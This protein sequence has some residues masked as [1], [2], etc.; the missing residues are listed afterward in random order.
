MNTLI[1]PPITTRCLSIAAPAFNE[2]EGIGALVEH[3][4]HFL[5]ENAAIDRFEIIICNDGSEDNTGL[6][7]EALAA[8]HSEI[9]LIHF[10]LNQGAAAALAAAIAAT[11]FDWVLLMDA[12]GQFPIENL[13]TMLAQLDLGEVKAVSGIRKK[14]D[15]LFARFGTQS[16]GLICNLVHGS[17]LKDFNSACKLVYGP[18]IRSL[19]LEARGMNYS[20][21]V[22]SKLLESRIALVEIDIDHR[23][24]PMGK[25]K[26]R[27]LRD[28]MHRLLFVAYISWRQLLFKLKILRR[29]YDNENSS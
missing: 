21:E 17:Q 8:L 28:S 2:G 13:S 7:L 15:H 16:S 24:R 3:W 26:L 10:K 27:W 9:R 18:V 1:T 14:K 11:R 25:S 19:N 12:D 23:P 6:V 22:T 29:A 5:N 4:H 20:T